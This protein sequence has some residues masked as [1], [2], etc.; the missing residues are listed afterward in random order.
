MLGSI[1]LCLILIGVCTCTRSTP[2]INVAACPIGNMG[3]GAPCAIPGAGALE[4]RLQCGSI[5]ALNAAI[6]NYVSG[7]Y[8]ITSLAV[9]GAGG[10]PAGLWPVRYIGKAQAGTGN[11]AVPIPGTVA[12]KG[13][14]GRVGNSANEHGLLGNYACVLPTIAY[15]NA[16]NYDELADM[17]EAMML[18]GF[19]APL[20]AYSRLGMY[21]Q[22]PVGGAPP[23]PTVNFRIGNLPQG[24][25]DIGAAA[26][27]FARTWN[28]VTNR[29]CAGNV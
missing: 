17:I 27:H 22:L 3:A 15:G 14:R 20:N 26:I 2:S 12:G 1:A 25:A 6:P 5:A 10:P 23:R 9:P 28:V 18:I 21:Q 7:V 11:Q 8:F 13:L 16:D 24:A 19:A 29:I 4:G